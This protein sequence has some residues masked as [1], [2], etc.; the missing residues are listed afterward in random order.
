MQTNHPSTRR[1]TFVLPLVIAGILPT[2]P[3]V[4]QQ[5][6]NG[7]L[8][9]IG[10]FRTLRVW[11]TPREMG[12][13]HGYL[14]ADDIV[15]DLQ[16]IL[17]T[18]YAG[19]PRQYESTRAALL[20]HIDLP[21]AAADEIHGVFA[22]IQAA[23]KGSLEL[24][25]M[26][27][28]LEPEDLVYLNALDVLRAFGCSGFTVWGDRAAGAGVITAR[29]F[30]YVAFTRRVHADQLLITRSPLGRHRTATVAWPGYIGVFTGFND[31]AVAVFIHD[32]NAPIDRRPAKRYVPLSLALLEWLETS[33]PD[34]AHA[35]AREMLRGIETPFSYMVRVVTPR[36]PDP[37]V[38]PVSVFRIDPTGLTET[39]VSGDRCITTNHYVGDTH[40]VSDSSRRRY[41]RIKRETRA[42]VT[43]ESAWNALRDVAVGGETSGT[44]HALLFYPEQRRLQLAFATWTEH[45]IG[46]PFTAPTTI[47]F[48]QLF[49]DRN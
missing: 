34:T 16:D 4:A 46:A 27:R 7:S 6:V 21:P 22:G 28:T 20:R 24:A 30:D 48:D 32:G 44:L 12:Y 36:L 42:T 10:P 39:H 43:P 31:A 47:T 15:D 38:K 17:R 26:R 33:E 9:R 11:G 37:A 2:L 1:R 14:L 8:D 19:N 3:A 29:N 40:P 5:G 18:F 13:A 25:A 49:P 41:R 35:S 23:H 45:I